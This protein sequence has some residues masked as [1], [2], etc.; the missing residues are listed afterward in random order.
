[1]LFACTHKKC[2][3]F[4]QNCELNKQ[5]DKLT[6]MIQSTPRDCR[7]IFVYAPHNRISIFIRMCPIDILFFITS[8]AHGVSRESDYLRT[9]VVS[10]TQHS[11]KM[12][13][14]ARGWDL[15]GVLA[16]CHIVL[17]ILE[18]LVFA[19]TG[20]LSQLHPNWCHSQWVYTHKWNFV[21]NDSFNLGFDS[22]FILDALVEIAVSFSAIGP[23]GFICLCSYFNKT[24]GYRWICPLWCWI[25]WMRM[26]RL[27]TSI[28]RL[29]KLRTGQINKGARSIKY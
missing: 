8:L 14:S 13:N 24:C 22:K 17:C 5:E 23:N 28:A 11:A 19:P 16:G 21:A 7:Y 4:G 9:V 26:F 25:N 2:T 15:L 3:N 6:P 10:W 20:E 18:R 27:A 29:S 12:W 1:M